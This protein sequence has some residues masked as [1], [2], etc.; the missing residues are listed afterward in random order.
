MNRLKRS[1]LHGSV[2]AL[3]LSAIALLTTVLLS[4]YLQPNITFFFLLAAWVCA[5]QYGRIVG[6]L[7]IAFSSVAIVYFFFRPDPTEGPPPW[8]T[9][10]RL[11][12]FVAIAGLITWMTS[13]W[14]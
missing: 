9:V 2:F 11:L 6:L 12:A 3:A 10:G 1:P 7:S 13:A 5:W 14:R 8:N 4:P